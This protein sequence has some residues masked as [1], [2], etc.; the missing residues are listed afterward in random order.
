MNCYIGSESS[1]LVAIFL[2]VTIFVG[3]VSR[4][5]YQP[6]ARRTDSVCLQKA[7]LVEGLCVLLA[8]LVMYLD[9]VVWKDKV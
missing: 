1:V 4:A 2:F 6:I 9:G 7:I 8:Y 3:R 5:V